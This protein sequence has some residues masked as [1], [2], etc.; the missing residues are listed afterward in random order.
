MSATKAKRGLP[1]KDVPPADLAVFTDLAKEEGIDVIRPDT[2][3]CRLFRWPAPQRKAL[4]R[5]LT[6][7]KAIPVSP[8]TGRPLALPRRELLADVPPPDPEPDEAEATP[9]AVPVG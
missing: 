6:F 8:R 1:L 3:L 9:A 7:T 5:H 4:E 2:P